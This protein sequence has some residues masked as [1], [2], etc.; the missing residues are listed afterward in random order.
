MHFGGR[1]NLSFIVLRGY[2]G[3]MVSAPPSTA[4]RGILYSSVNSLIEGFCP[5]IMLGTLPSFDFLKCR[6]TRRPVGSEWRRVDVEPEALGAVER[7]GQV[8]GI[9]DPAS[10]V[11]RSPCRI[12]LVVNTSLS[13]LGTP[14]RRSNP[15]LKWVVVATS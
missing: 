5:G 1:T 11:I 15:A 2:S 12:K 8:N 9:V 6:N 14:L 7:L 13:L 4:S 10:T 3:Y